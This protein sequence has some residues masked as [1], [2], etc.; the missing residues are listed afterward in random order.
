[1]K[2]MPGEFVPYDICAYATP[3]VRVGVGGGGASGIAGP[4]GRVQSTDLYGL[5]G[6]RR[7]SIERC[8]LF[9]TV[10]NLSTQS[11]TSSSAVTGGHW[12]WSVIHMSS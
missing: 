9:I 1:M 7:L 4:R 3:D 11:C 10:Q 8:A 2:G 5:Y 12:L 6:G